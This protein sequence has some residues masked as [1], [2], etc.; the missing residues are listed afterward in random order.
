MPLYTRVRAYNGGHCL[1][2]TCR[3]RRPL[4]SA[5]LINFSI[6][7]MM[8]A[9]RERCERGKSDR[10]YDVI[11]VF[12]PDKRAELKIITIVCVCVCVGEDEA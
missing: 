7:I 1:S 10:I 5:T 6:I 8:M 2:L 12:W 11:G 3:V 9:A 4:E